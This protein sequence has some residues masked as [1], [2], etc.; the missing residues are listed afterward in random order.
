MILGTE[1]PEDHQKAT[2]VI[3]R[4]S[5]VAGYKVIHR[6]Q[7]FLYANNKVVERQK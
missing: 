6:D 4:F 5:K 2:K 7:L 1:N 3:N